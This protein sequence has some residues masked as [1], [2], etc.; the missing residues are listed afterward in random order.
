MISVYRNDGLRKALQALHARYATLV[1]GITTEMRKWMTLS[2]FFIGKAGPASISEALLSGLPLLIDGRG[3]YL[4]QERFNIEWIHQQG[5][6][7]V[8][9]RG[10][11]FVS[12]FLQP[13]APDA[14]TP[15]RETAAGLENRAVFEF[16]DLV[17]EI[18]GRVAAA[19]RRAKAS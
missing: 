4:P 13:I 14:L 7:L 2:D 9:D 12:A 6:G 8:V 16:A 3:G 1:L 11:D 18:R 17:E 10:A 5:V 15:Y 19:S